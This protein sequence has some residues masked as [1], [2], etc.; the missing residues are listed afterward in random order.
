MDTDLTNTTVY[1]DNL[2]P[3]VAEEG[4]R[5]IFLQFGEIVYVKIPAAKGCRFVQ[6]VNRTSAEEAIQR[7]HGSQ[8]GLTVVHLSWGKS[9]A[10]KQ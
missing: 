10:A 6:F 4:L 1:I 3:G 9:T 8:I 2:D 7:M 5:S